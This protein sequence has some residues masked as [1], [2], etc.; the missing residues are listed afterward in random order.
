MGVISNS[1]ISEKRRRK[2]VVVVVVVIS[3][4]VESHVHVIEMSLAL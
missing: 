4:F 2:V 1:T 3:L